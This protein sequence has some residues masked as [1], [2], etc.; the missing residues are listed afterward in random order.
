MIIAN[1]NGVFKLFIIL[2]IVEFACFLCVIDIHLSGTKPNKGSLKVALRRFSEILELRLLPLSY[3]SVHMK[4]LGSDLLDFS[5]I[6]YLSTFPKICPENWSFIN[7]WQEKRALYVK[8][9]VHL[10]LFTDFF[11]EWEIFQTKVIEKIK[12]HILCSVTFLPRKSRR[13]WRNVEK[14]CRAGQTT[15]DNITRRMRTSCW[16]SKATD[17]TLRIGNNL[18]FSTK[19]MV[20]R[21]RLNVTLYV[22]CL[23]LL[24]TT[25][26]TMIWEET[27]SRVQN[28]SVCLLTIQCPPGCF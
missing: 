25:F 14:C 21:T 2:E 15:D 13:L 24:A 8:N 26:V 5:Q 11:L 1:N 22:D 17:Y 23:S 18:C 10:W 6:W 27:I 20:T 28:S 9:N 12:T 7:L 4:N 19:T 3:L 16:I